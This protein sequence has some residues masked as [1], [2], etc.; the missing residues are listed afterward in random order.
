MSSKNLKHKSGEWLL[1]SSEDRLKNFLVPRV[2]SRIETYHLTFLTFLWSFLIVVCFYLGRQDALFLF[3]VPL[4]VILQYLSDLL[5]GAV[6]RY[7]DTGLVKWGYYVDHFLDFIFAS[8]IVFGYGLILG[9]S[10]WIFIIEFMISAFMV[11]T[12]LLVSVNQSFRI[13]FFRLGPTEG[14]SIFIFVHLFFVWQG[15]K[16]VGFLFPFIALGA[17]VFLAIMFIINQKRLWQEDMKIK[18]EKNEN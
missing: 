7:R 10:V 1:K 13:S 15:L 2:P 18:N 3:L 9:F 12:F 6:G 11:H 14:R 8:S 5:D 16:T 17:L 4:F